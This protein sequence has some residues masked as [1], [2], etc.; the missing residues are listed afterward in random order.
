[1]IR[2][3]KNWVVLVLVVLLFACGGSLTPEQKEKA[4]KAIEEGKIKRITPAQITEAA[5]NYGKRISTTVNELDP[6]LNNPEFIDSIATINQVVIY[7]L[8]PD[9]ESLSKEESS[10]ADAY[11]AQGDIT[12]VGENIQQLAGDSLLFT[13]PVG[14]ER[15]DGSRPFSHAIAIKMSVKQIVLSIEE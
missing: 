10:I 12:G 2:F 11:Q 9:M 7:A 4:R 6:F 14:N 1:M 13:Y 8:R 15:P 5:L 3:S